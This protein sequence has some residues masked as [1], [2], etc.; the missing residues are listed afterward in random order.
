MAGRNLPEADLAKSCYLLL[1]A[2]VSAGAV[3]IYGFRRVSSSGFGSTVVRKMVVR[4][5]SPAAFF[6]ALA[7]LCWVLSA[8]E[9]L[10]R[11]KFDFWRALIS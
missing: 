3:M 1:E 6:L 4:S 9:V 11:F 10:Q 2:Y 8:D 5:V 7:V